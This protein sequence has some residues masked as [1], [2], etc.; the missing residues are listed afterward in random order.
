MLI[1]STVVLAC[2]GYFLK[3]A[4][5][6]PVIQEVEFDNPVDGSFCSANRAERQLQAAIHLRL[7]RN[8]SD[9]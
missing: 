5:S 7:A 1:G 8:A 6:A 2:I 4:I 3:E 9:Q